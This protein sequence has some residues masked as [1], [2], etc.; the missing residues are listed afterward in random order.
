MWGGDSVVVAQG[1]YRCPDSENSVV[2]F[3]SVTENPACT[4]DTVRLH[5]PGASVSMCSI[6]SSRAAIAPVYCGI[7]LLRKTIAA[8]YTRPIW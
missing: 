8:L 4:D 7:S 5:H 3:P 1:T 6:A 2:S